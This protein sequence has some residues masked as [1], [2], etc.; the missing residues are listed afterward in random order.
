MLQATG[1]VPI[2]TPPLHSPSLIISFFADGIIIQKVPV[3]WDLHSHERWPQPLVV[4]L[5]SA[6]FVITSS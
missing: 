4:R 1:T 5:R 3:V 2:A 6:Y